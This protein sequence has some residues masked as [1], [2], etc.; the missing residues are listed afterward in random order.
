MAIDILLSPT[1]SGPICFRW[2]LI[3]SVT[4]QNS[5]AEPPI[6][7]PTRQNPT[8]IKVAGEKHSSY[9]YDKKIIFRPEWNLL[10][11]ASLLG[12]MKVRFRVVARR[13]ADERAWR[14]WV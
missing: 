2:Q 11:S 3:G 8:S 13:R 5:E 7:H 4:I 12:R 1:K 14:G 9:C 6:G 10:L